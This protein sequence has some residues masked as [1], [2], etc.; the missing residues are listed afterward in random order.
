MREPFGNGDTY[1]AIGYQDWIPLILS[2]RPIFIA[3]NRPFPSLQL[4]RYILFVNIR[5]RFVVAF[6]EISDRVCHPPSYTDMKRLFP[7]TKLLQ[8]EQEEVG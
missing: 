4:N 7:C 3:S 5:E 2:F 8:F 1:G 6:V